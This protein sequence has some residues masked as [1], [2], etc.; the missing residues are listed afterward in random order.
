MQTGRDILSWTS[1]EALGPYIVFVY[2]GFLRDRKIENS[3]PIDLNYL[4]IGACMGLFKPAY[5][6]SSKT[7]MYRSQGSPDVGVPGPLIHRRPR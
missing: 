2:I 7:K 3:H 4:E 1:T 5:G 6:R